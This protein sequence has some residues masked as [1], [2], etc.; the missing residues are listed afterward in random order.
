M[1]STLFS[2]QG[3]WGSISLDIIIPDAGAVIRTSFRLLNAISYAS[4][5][6]FIY[7]QRFL[8]FYR[9]FQARFL[10]SGSPSATRSS[11][12][13]NCFPRQDR[14]SPFEL[15]L[16]GKDVLLYL[17][18]IKGREQLIFAYV[19]VE[20]NIDVVDN[21][22]LC[23]YHRCESRLSSFPVTDIVFWTSPWVTVSYFIHDIYLELQLR[24]DRIQEH[25]REKDAAADKSF[26][27]IYFFE[28]KEFSPNPTM[29]DSSARAIKY[30]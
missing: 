18:G 30:P 14:A 3:V 23:A 22:V 28:H 27:E 19:L 24:Y 5:F 17:G 15:A 8:V 6:L 21:T 13:G 12:S 9:P 4:L 29:F 7:G 20:I 25:D 16:H 26:P 1:K 10:R 2:W 11:R